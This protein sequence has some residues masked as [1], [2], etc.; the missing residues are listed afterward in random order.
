MKKIMVLLLTMM[1]VFA[2][3]T[4]AMAVTVVGPGVTFTGATG[5]KYSD[6]SEPY[7]NV[8]VFSAPTD[9]YFV[10]WVTNNSNGQQ[11][12]PAYYFYSAGTKS[13]YYMT[14]SRNAGYVK[15]GVSYA[16]R[17]RSGATTPADEE[18]TIHI[19]F[20]P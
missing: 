3:T 1:L 6:D 18:S 11:V 2:M 19:A 9:C 15:A 10:F 13:V 14:E 20:N 8:L 16:A 12:T 7:V 5:T 17:F 4:S